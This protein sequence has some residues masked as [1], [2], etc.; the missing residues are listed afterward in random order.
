[1]LKYT[2]QMYV[3]KKTDQIF[4]D[5][6]VVY[7]FYLLQIIIVFSNTFRYSFLAIIILSSCYKNNLYAKLAPLIFGK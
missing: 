6:V 4:C 3:T 2:K 5:L 1:M 7:R